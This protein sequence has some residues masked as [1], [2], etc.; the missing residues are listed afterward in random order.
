[1]TA[2][3]N[4][5]RPF[6]VMAE[7]KASGLTLILDSFDEYEQA[8]EY[9]AERLREYGDFMHLWIDRPSRRSPARRAAA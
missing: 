6:K 3:P 8:R 9:L 4:T 5:D 7:G 1:M 2:T